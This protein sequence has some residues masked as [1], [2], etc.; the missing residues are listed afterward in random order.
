MF[1]E[2]C[3]TLEWSLDIFS[4]Y[5][6]NLLRLENTNEPPV[7]IAIV[8]QDEA[9]AFYD[10]GL[11]LDSRSEAMESRPGQNRLIRWVLKERKSRRRRRHSRHHARRDPS[12]LL[13]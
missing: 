2:P 4:W 13:S 10:A 12:R 8:H 1:I 3:E 9:I 5:V 7:A 6:A 11:A